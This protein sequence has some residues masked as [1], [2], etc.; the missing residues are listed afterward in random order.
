MFLVYLLS[1]LSLPW[2]LRGYCCSEIG[3]FFLRTFLY[4]CCMPMSPDVSHNIILS[5]PNCAQMTSQVFSY[6]VVFLYITM[7]LSILP[8][9]DI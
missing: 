2:F 1:F 8:L 7:Y 9:R 4:F 6:S 3:M 5:V